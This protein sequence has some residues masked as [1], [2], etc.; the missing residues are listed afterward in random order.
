[1]ATARGML[2]RV[3]VVSLETFRECASPNLPPPGPVG[4]DASAETDPIRPMLSPA[5]RRLHPAAL[6]A[7]LAVHVA[8]AASLLW[9]VSDRGAKAAGQGGIVMA[10]EIAGAAAGSAVETPGED[11]D[12]DTEQANPQKTPETEEVVETE[13]PEREAAPVEEQTAEAVPEPA[14]EPVPEAAPEVSEEPAVQE[15]PE[16]EIVQ[17]P[18]T[19]PVVE[20]VEPPPEVVP[21]EPP[22][23]FSAIR[24][25]RRP[26]PP[27]PQ[28]AVREAERKSEPASA[29]PTENERATE[30]SVVAA[31]AGEGGLAERSEVEGKG[32]GT[33]TAG[34]GLVG[35][36]TDYFAMLRAWLEQHK[37]YP[38]RARVRRE[39]GTVLLRVT[40]VPG[41]DLLAYSVQRSSGHPELDRAAESMIKRA[42]PF[43][44]N[45]T[46]ANGTLE[47]VVPVSFLLQ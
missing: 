33:S 2:A 12:S 9:E 43:P 47:V 19:E 3:N 31:V 23:E 26:N 34:G 22:K 30:K 15:V 13:T 27:V 8:V 36:S 17:P 5:G 21:P 41:G 39:Q 45:P 7:A 44:P 20:A 35:A 4:G 42:Q 38:R 14:A 11:R 1:M 25:S 32:S 37:E 40:F 28:P 46:G 10:F 16:P 24:P 6:L 18:D 29:P